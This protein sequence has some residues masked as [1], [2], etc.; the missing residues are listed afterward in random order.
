MLS[1]VGC[2]YV[3][4][5]CTPVTDRGGNRS[6]TAKRPQFFRRYAPDRGIFG[7]TPV[8]RGA[9]RQDP[10][11]DSHPREGFFCHSVKNIYDA[12]SRDLARSI[13]LTREYHRITDTPRPSWQL[14]FFIHPTRLSSA[15]SSKQGVSC[16]TQDWL[17]ELSYLFRQ[18]FL[19]NG[20]DNQ[21]I[22]KWP[23]DSQDLR[24]R[25]ASYRC[26][27]PRPRAAASRC[28]LILLIFLL[29]HTT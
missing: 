24:C 29:Q 26:L 9:T 7:A 11:D 25:T 5:R 12:G 19:K 21:R 15:N 1:V 16:L 10:L 3:C 18:L 6:K 22:L 27:A 23:Q 8:E 20:S 28:M 4:Y 14:F 17:R 2:R 13:L